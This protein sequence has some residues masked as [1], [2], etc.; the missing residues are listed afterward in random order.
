[1]LII[2]LVQTALK[3]PCAL[4]K[5]MFSSNHTHWKYS[6][7]SFLHLIWY[8][9]L[10]SSFGS[11]TVA[12]SAGTTS[13]GASVVAPG[14]TYSSSGPAGSSVLAAGASS[15]VPPLISRSRAVS[16]SWHKEM[17][18]T[19]LKSYIGYAIQHMPI[20]I[21]ESNTGDNLNML[22]S[23]HVFPHLPGDC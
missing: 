14:D 10:S 3:P 20:M 22:M 17:L 19:F 9:R 13:V 1:M 7:L 11:T 5:R 6:N 8:H 23:Q 18:K 15:P 21:K 2:L 16:L 12:L 4:I